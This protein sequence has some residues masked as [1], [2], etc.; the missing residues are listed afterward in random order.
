MLDLKSYTNGVLARNVNQ[1]LQHIDSQLSSYMS[2]I[3]VKLG[4]MGWA[5]GA[6]NQ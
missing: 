5:T 6:Y 1:R 2:H 4:G 3:V